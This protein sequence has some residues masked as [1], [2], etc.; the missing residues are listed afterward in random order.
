MPGSRSEPR[1][2]PG[3]LPRPSDRP[4]E[5]CGAS[6]P[7]SCPIA[8]CSNAVRSAERS[9]SIEPREFEDTRHGTF[10]I[11]TGLRADRRDGGLRAGA[12][13]AGHDIAALEDFRRGHRMLRGIVLNQ[14]GGASHTTAKTADDFAD[15]H[16]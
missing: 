1:R 13:D 6:A 2:C 10:N 12:N 9:G 8:R 7:T 14:D 11:L 15:C 4:S 5:G 3:A 16:G